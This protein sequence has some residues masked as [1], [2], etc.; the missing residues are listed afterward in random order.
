MAIGLTYEEV[1]RRMNEMHP[2]LELL[3][4]HYVNSITKMRVRCSVCGYEYLTTW[5]IL[6]G[7]HGCGR[8]SK[9]AKL[10]IEVIRERFADLNP[11]GKILDDEYVNNKEKIHCSCTVCGHKWEKS[12]DSLRLYPY[13]P[14][15][16]RKAGRKKSIPKFTMDEIKIMSDKI[17]PDIIILDDYYVNTSSPIRVRC[18][19]DGNVWTSSWNRLQIKGC[20]ECYLRNNRGEN[21]KSW[22]GGITPLHNHLRTTI[23]PWKKDSMKKSNYRCVITGKPFEEIHHEHGFEFILKETME[24]V[25][26]PIHTKINEYTESE[27]KE[28]EDTCL[29]LHYK[30]GLGS[31]ILA[32]LHTEFHN[33][34]GRGKNTR[35]QFEEFLELKKAEIKQ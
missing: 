10:T 18:R 22:K 15:C 12:W 34:Y 30:Y 25:N 29:E 21:H 19:I 35:E 2:T 8:C 24:I 16:N 32:S 13:C 11:T 4:D 27:L 17:N 5:T 1:I 31:P 20:R 23:Y 3:E 7:N 6:S 14:E 33:I 28:I 9:V 26:L